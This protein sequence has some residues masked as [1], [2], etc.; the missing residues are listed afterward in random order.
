[1]DDGILEK[2]VKKRGDEIC[3]RRRTLIF[4]LF[5]LNPRRMLY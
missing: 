4:L 3:G 5:F 2:I 1:M